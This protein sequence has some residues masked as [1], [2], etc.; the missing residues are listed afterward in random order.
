MFN[1]SKAKDWTQVMFADRICAH[2]KYL[3]IYMIVI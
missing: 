3:Y 1:F 2:A